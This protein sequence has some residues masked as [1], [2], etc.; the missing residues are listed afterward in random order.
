MQRQ[1]DQLVRLVDDLLDVSRISTGKLELRKE[2]VNLKEV[3][4][5]AVDASRPLIDRM[6][7]QLNVTLPKQTLT[8]D[9]DLARLGQVFCIL[10][11]NAA[12]YM[13][14]GGRIWLA[15]ERQGSDVLVSVKDT[16][17]GIAAD[18]LEGIFHMFSQVEGTLDRSQGGLGIGLTLV[19]R[20]VE[21]HDGRIEAHS[22]GSGKGSEFVVRLPVVVE[23]SGP[24]A[25]EPEPPAPLAISCP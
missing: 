1:L 16:G 7:H 19:R 11:N 25:P 8:V 15:V 22:E 24:L 5:S 12:K 2:R 13:D 21:M 4:S 6:G 10:L 18:H 20:L 17:V 23:A 9:A 14:R 3:V